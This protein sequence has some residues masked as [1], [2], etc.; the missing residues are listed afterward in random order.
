MSPMTILCFNNLYTRHKNQWWTK[1]TKMNATNWADPG[2]EQKTK[3]RIR[4]R[5]GKKVLK[6]TWMAASSSIDHWLDY[7]VWFKPYKT[8]LWIM[9]DSKVQSVF[10]TTHVFKV[11]APILNTTS[12]LNL[13]SDAG[14]FFSNSIFPQ[15]MRFFLPSV[16]EKGKFEISNNR[17]SF[18]WAKRSCNERT[19]IFWFEAFQD[20]R[21]CKI[22]EGVGKKKC[23]LTGKETQIHIWSS[24]EIVSA[25][26]HKKE[27]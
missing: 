24:L 1:R 27:S 9:F 18:T 15:K 5:Q 21:H 19:L 22:I 26:W 20:A 3:G 13:R 11:I 8:R 6:T 25:Y 16:F 10:H 23:P 17:P 7:S 2:G 12:V 4:R 14:V